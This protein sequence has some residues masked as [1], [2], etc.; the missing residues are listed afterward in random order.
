MSVRISELTEATTIEDSD[1]LPIVQSGT[2]KKIP[3]NK[4]KY[5]GVSVWQG[6]Q[7]EYDNLESRSS[8]TLYIIHE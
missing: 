5:I 1:V 7:E 6:T 3:Y 8:E 4:I 2:T